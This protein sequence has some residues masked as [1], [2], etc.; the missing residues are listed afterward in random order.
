MVVLTPGTRSLNSSGKTDLLLSLILHPKKHVPNASL[1]CVC[2]LL[3]Y[4]LMSQSLFY[5]S[6]AG[7]FFLPMG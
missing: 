3:R 7:K 6:G 4:L 5:F 1:N 2:A